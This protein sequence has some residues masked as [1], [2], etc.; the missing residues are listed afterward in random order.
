[1]SYWDKYRNQHEPK[2]HWEMRKRF[3]EAHKDTFDEDRLLC[4]AQTFYNVE[5]LGCKY[6]ELVMK[7]IEELSKGKRVPIL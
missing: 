2:E 7:Q 3:F 4:L 5:F 1:M 6:P